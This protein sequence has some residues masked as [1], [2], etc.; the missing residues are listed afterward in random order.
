MVLA[1]PQVGLGIGFRASNGQWL[2][3]IYI[4]GKREKGKVW[5]LCPSLERKRSPILN[6]YPDGQ[7]REREKIQGKHAGKL[8]GCGAKE[9][10]KRD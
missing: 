3:W 2:G 9:G 4:L 8:W 7:E 10:D 5:I 6:L 1:F